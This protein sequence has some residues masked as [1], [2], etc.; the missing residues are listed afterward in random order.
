MMAEVATIIIMA[1]TGIGVLLDSG[2]SRQSNVRVR[3]EEAWSRRLPLTLPHRPSWCGSRAAASVAMAPPLLY[4]LTH[5]DLPGQRERQSFETEMA[6]A[7]E[8][9]APLPPPPLLGSP[10]FSKFLT[11]DHSAHP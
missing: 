10:L 7:S 5:N 11:P 9:P 3:R 2:P 4:I 8:P 1:A 6:T